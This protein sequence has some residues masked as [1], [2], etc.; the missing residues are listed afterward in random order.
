MASKPKTTT[1][2]AAPVKAA[3]DD[4]VLAAGGDDTII[5]KGGGSGAASEVI[6]TFIGSQDWTI[7]EGERNTVVTIPKNSKWQIE[8]DAVSGD[9]Y[10]ECG[11]VKLSKARINEMKDAT[12][13]EAPARLLPKR[14]D[15]WQI[16]INCEVVQS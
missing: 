16:I 9:Y 1:Q 8:R 2:A 13:N 12:G 14:A 5:V 15:T 7:E 6:T 3:L 10:A 4:T 11:Q